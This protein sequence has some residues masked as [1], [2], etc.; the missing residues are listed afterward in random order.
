M[1]GNTLHR[2][3][4]NSLRD[5]PALPGSRRLVVV[6]PGNRR[7]WRETDVQRRPRGLCEPRERARRGQHLAP[8]SLSLAGNVK[9]PRYAAPAAH[10]HLPERTTQVLHVGSCI[11]CNPNSSIMKENRASCA[12]APA[13]QPAASSP[14]LRSV[15]CL[16]FMAGTFPGHERFQWPAIRSGTR[17]RGPILLCQAR[18]FWTKRTRG[19]PSKCRSQVSKSAS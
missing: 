12:V 8:F 4:P 6:P 3:V 13:Y 17:G 5:A 18:R 10:P 19:K 11:R 1:S 15:P 2:M 16:P 14:S 7:S 9:R